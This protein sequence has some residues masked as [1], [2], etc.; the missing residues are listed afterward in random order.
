MSDGR[1]DSLPDTT[2]IVISAPAVVDSDGDGLSDDQ[3]RRIGTNPNN[4]DTDGDGFG[5]RAELLA[6]SNP[7]AGASV[8]GFALDLLSS[9]ATAF[10]GSM[11]TIPF[12]IRRDNGSADTVSINLVNP[13]TGISAPAVLLAS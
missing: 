13:P 8:P 4:P 10:A 9:S 7:T 2:D 5:D 3:E 1:L 11:T 12:R 6:G